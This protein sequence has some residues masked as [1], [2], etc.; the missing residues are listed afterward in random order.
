[1]IHRGSPRSDHPLLSVNCAALP[2]HLLESELFGHV[3]G[4]F[5]GAERDRI[6]RFEAADKGTI[7]LD[8]IGDMA[9]AAQAKM[10]R[11][12]QEGTFEPVGSNTAKRVDVRVIAATN[13]D[14]AAEV[15][16]GRFRRDLYYR[17]NI[18]AIALPPLRER[19]E[20]VPSLA[21]HFIAQ[22]AERNRK[23][24]A[25]AA[26][27]FLD[28]LMRYD[29]PGNVRELE[30][31][32]ER[33]VI[34]ALSDDLTPDLLPPNIRAAA[35]ESLPAP[36]GAAAVPLTTLYE[37][38]RELILRTL[39]A[40]HGNQSQAARQLGISRQTLINKLKQYRGE[41]GA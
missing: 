38:E 12:L 6:G 26:G 30:N 10:L 34:L 40:C 4:A 7:F 13:H 16:E 41:A 29:W 1:A 5:T 22:Y 8:E 17:L 24:V 19:R 27:P 35:P 9:P 39:D 37:A 28:C 31:S 36:A 18:V 33:C 32:I 23:R 25:P 11:V 21:N 20:D 2:E 3:R 14:L 15:E